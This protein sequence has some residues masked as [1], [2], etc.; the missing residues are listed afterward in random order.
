[1]KAAFDMCECGQEHAI[2]DHGVRY[3]I[4][5][6]DCCLRFVGSGTFD[7]WWP[8]S[9][10]TITH[11]VMGFEEGFTLGPSW[12]SLSWSFESTESLPAGTGRPGWSP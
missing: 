8:S 11:D 4:E 6:D 2:L 5:A 12:A 3:E 1:M 7:Q 10:G 9:D